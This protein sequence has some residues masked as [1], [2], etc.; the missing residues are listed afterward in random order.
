QDEAGA[1]TQM[2]G[3]GQRKDSLPVRQGGVR[4][5]QIEAPGLPQQQRRDADDA[6][7]QIRRGPVPHTA[8]GTFSE[9]WQAARWSR[10]FS[11]RG[12]S[13]S[14][15]G[16]GTWAIGQRGWNR[17]PDGGLTGEG[18]SPLRWTIRRLA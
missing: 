5:M 4:G 2:A 17:Q 14:A 18:I 10:A 15:H 12:G 8:T 9:K 11:S 13:R 6:G 1:E 16:V 7:R 3:V